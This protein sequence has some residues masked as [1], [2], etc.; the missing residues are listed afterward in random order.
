MQSITNPKINVLHTCKTEKNDVVLE[1]CKFPNTSQTDC[2]SF[3]NFVVIFRTP[4]LQSL[5]EVEQIFNYKSATFD[6]VV[7]MYLKHTQ[8][9]DVIAFL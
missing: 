9:S 5:V 7:L 4:A 2:Q 8:T 1:L 6:L 3:K